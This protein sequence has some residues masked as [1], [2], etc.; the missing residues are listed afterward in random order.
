MDE[1]DKNEIK[2]KINSELSQ[3]EAQI[4]S[5]VEVTQPISPDNALGRITRMDAIN[6]KAVN[7]SALIKSR[8]R[9]QALETAISNLEKPDFGLCMRCKNPIPIKRLLYI[10]EAKSCVQCASR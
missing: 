4:K 9:K 10:P 5:L 8:N 1:K 7:E 6:N 2:D 3:L